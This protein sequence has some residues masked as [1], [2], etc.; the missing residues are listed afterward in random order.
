MES[1]LKSLP[2]NI[3]FV[4]LQSLS[5]IFLLVMRSWHQ[6]ALK[7]NYLPQE[8]AATAARGVHLGKTL[9]PFGVPL[10]NYT[11]QCGVLSGLGVGVCF[12]HN[13]PLPLP[14]SFTQG[15]TRMVVGLAGLLG[16]FFAG[17]AV[18]K[19]AALKGSPVMIGCMRFLRF[20][21]V[22]IYILVYGPYIF[23]WYE[24]RLGWQ[25]KEPVAQDS[26][27]APTA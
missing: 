1:F 10:T 13:V 21:F 2:F 25:P 26:V 12:L 6:H 19:S 18:E 8:W 27:I 9:D 15:A 5:V 17:S 14:T 11:G 23:N 20:Q 7:I 24:K 4:S 16:P 22:P 3:R